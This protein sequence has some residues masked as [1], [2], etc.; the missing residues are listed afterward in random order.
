[1]CAVPRKLGGARLCS[2][3]DTPVATKW[4]RESVDKRR[5]ERVQKKKEENNQDTGK[6][7]R[8]RRHNDWRRGCYTR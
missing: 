3:S 8:R 4:W 2:P 1:V 6:L 7:N 5:P